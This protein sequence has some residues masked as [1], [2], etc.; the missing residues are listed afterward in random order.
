MEIQKSIYTSSS[1]RARKKRKTASSSFTAV[2]AETND[3]QSSNE[4]SHSSNINPLNSILSLQEISIQDE[5]KR[6]GRTYGDMLLNDL[7]HLRNSIL[8]GK[9]S[10]S[11]L[12]SIQKNIE[13]ARPDVNDLQL[14]QIMNDIELRA[15]VE[16]AKYKK[17][18]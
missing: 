6:R 15:K 5:E 7:E 3:A 14:T 18:A 9:V 4:T 13:T 11:Q 1:S 12:E 10:I 8:S 17:Y 2:L 16:I